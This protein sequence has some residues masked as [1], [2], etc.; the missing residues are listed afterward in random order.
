[1]VGDGDFRN[2]LKE[3][4]KGAPDAIQEFQLAISEARETITGFQKV[5]ERADTNLQNLEDFTAALGSDGP[6]LIQRLKSTAG[7]A[8]E[9]LNQIN[10]IAQQLATSDGTLGKFVNDPSLYNNLN[11]TLANARDLTIRLKPLVNDLRLFA[12]GLARDPGQIVRGAF[13]GRPNNGA[14]KPNYMR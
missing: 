6:E 11:E 12:D 3:S 7:T 4:L 10:G 5:T 2:R 9:F 1:M 13:D 14:Y 8:D